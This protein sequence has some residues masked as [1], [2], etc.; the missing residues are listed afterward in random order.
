MSFEKRAR[1]AQIAELIQQREFYGLKKA[2][3]QV[4]QTRDSLSALDQKEGMQSHFSVA[5]AMAQERHAAHVLEQ[6]YWLNQK[7]AVQMA[8]WHDQRDK[9]QKAFGR[10]EVLKKWPL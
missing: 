4:A 9:A 3:D 2:S 5:G 6:R 8:D 10:C 7:L 1:L